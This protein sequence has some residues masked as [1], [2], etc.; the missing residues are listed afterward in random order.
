MELPNFTVAETSPLVKIH[1]YKITKTDCNVLV[2]L[3]I[4]LQEQKRE[5]RY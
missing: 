4:F 5:K 1:S 2:R 3:N